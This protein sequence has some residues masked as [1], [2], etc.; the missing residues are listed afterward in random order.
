MSLSCVNV[1]LFLLASRKGWGVRVPRREGLVAVLN[2][3]KVKGGEVNVDK[4]EVEA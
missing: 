4:R 1:H 2:E 3:G